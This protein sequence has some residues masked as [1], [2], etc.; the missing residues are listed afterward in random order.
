MKRA[1][2]LIAVV[3]L[4]VTSIPSFAQQQSDTSSQY[5]KQVYYKVVSLMKVWTHQLGYVVQFFNSQARVQDV[6]IPLTWF[7]N[8][9][10]SKADIVYGL[11]RSYPYMTIFW[12]DGQFDHVTLYVS[13]DDSSQTNGVLPASADIADKF[14]VQDIPRE[15]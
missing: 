9:M 5:P 12:A 3:A 13:S 7:N 2:L 1:G 15:F 14:K 4:L 8:G 6:Y 11:D 10:Q